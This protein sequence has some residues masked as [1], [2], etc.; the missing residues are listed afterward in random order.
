M[1]EHSAC[2][3]VSKS[4]GEP[5][6][7]GDISEQFGVGLLVQPFK[8][9]IGRHETELVRDR[10]QHTDRFLAPDL[11][12]AARKIVSMAP[13]CR[14]VADVLFQPLEDPFTLLVGI[15]GTHRCI[16]DLI[17]LA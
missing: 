2:C 3:S 17:P 6:V 12:F 13:D 5:V 1:G 14:E 9:R 11:A 15:P 10:D 4:S 8:K 16:N 7:G